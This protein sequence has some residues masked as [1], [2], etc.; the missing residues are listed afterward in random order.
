MS[1]H[2]A[3]DDIVGM[4]RVDQAQLDE[5]LK[6]AYHEVHQWRRAAN[7]ETWTHKLSKR[8]FRWAGH[9]ARMSDD[10]PAKKILMWRGSA[11]LK[12]QELRFGRGRQ[13][14]RRH[15]HVRRWESW[16]ARWRPD[17]EA[18]HKADI[19]HEWMNTAQDRVEW[20]RL[21][22]RHADW[23]NTVRFA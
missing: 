22:E 5:A 6:K 2:N 10:R 14:H 3:Q 17:I 1:E 23:T 12:Q 8:R 4:N 7:I 18:D 16:I 13:G 19:S 11:W 21:A 20:C 9:V 15:L